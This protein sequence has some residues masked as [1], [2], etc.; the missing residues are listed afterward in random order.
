MVVSYGSCI[1]A[2]TNP[3][4]VD[5]TP[6]FLHTKP[7]YLTRDSIHLGWPPGQAAVAMIRSWFEKDTSPGKSTEAMEARSPLWIWQSQPHSLRVDWRIWRLMSAVGKEVLT[8]SARFSVYLSPISA[9]SFDLTTRAGDSSSNFWKKR[10]TKTVEIFWK[11]LHLPIICC[12]RICKKSG[13]AWGW[14]NTYGTIASSLAGHGGGMT[15]W[16]HGCIIGSEVL[17]SFLFQLQAQPQN[18]AWLDVPRPR[19]LRKKG[20]LLKFPSYESMI[21]T[22]SSVSLDISP[23]KKRN[24]FQVIFP[25]TSDKMWQ[26]VTRDLGPASLIWQVLLVLSRKNVTPE[27]DGWEYGWSMSIIILPIQIAILG[28]MSPPFLE[29]I[30]RWREAL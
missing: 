11:M 10:W 28:P 19:E 29:P 9:L 16:T 15:H 26:D 5:Q 2:T 25:P 24:D 12:W 23:A 6:S 20:K 1:E 4:Y 22:Q 7:C 13:T 8:I 18:C 27:A 21:S 17:R 30:E 14:V 3:A